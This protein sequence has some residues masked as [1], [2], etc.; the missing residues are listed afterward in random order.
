MLVTPGTPPVR[1]LPVIVAAWSLLSTVQTSGESLPSSKVMLVM[2]AGTIATFTVITPCTRIFA[3]FRLI[4]LTRFLTP[5]AK[6]HSFVCVSF[7][8]SGLL[9][10][11]FAAGGVAFVLVSGQY[12]VRSP[13]IQVS[14]LYCFVF[15]SPSEGLVQPL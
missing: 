13:S 12:I 2:V 10:L 11:G 8:G 1:K 9:S 4:S 14:R 15:A 6:T 7:V 5:L 3:E